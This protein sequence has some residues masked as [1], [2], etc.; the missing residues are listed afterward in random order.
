MKIRFSDLLKKAY[1]ERKE[2]DYLFF[3]EE[4]GYRGIRLGDFIEDAVCL[5]K[6]L[7]AKG[8][9]GKKIAVYGENSPRWMIADLAVC[10]YV[11]ISVGLS[12]EYRSEELRESLSRFGIDLLFFAESRRDTVSRLREEFP[13]LCCLSLE[14]D[15]PLLIAQGRKRLQ[16]ESALFDFEERDPDACVKVVLTAGTTSAPKAVMLSERNIFAGWDSLFRRAPM[17]SSDRCYLF[18]PLHHTYAGIY[19]FIYSLISG[20]QIYLSSASEKIAEELQIVRPTVFCGVPIIFRNF[21][22]S[23]AGDMEKLRS[24]FGENIKYLFTGGAYLE[25]EIREFYHRAGLNLLSAYALSETSSSLA[26]EY[27]GSRDARSVGRVF[28]DLQVRIGSPDAKGRGEILVRGEAV[29]LGYMND[30]KATREAFDEEGFFRTG[31][32]GCLDER[33][34]LYL[35][36]RKKKI[37]LTGHG[38]NIYPEAI[39]EKLKAG[40]PNINKVKIFVSG[41]ELR[42]EFYVRQ[43]EDFDYAGLVERYN[44]AVPS[45]RKISKFHVFTDSVDRRMK[46]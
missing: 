16:D 25:E 45:Y 9:K 22:A 17:D 30:E 31:D 14:K 1:A 6:A 11:G 4:E 15:L 37:L 5:A 40:N 33:N 20:M 44:R 2:Q 29:F 12:K 3:R 43:A 26:I 42:A 28:E 34:N 38:E 32:I 21:Y 7:L 27:S 39:E 23:A 36:G 46:Q 19:N 35:T 41:D 24:F 10:A 13:D 18:L 8:L